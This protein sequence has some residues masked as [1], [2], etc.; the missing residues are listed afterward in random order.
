MAVKGVAAPYAPVS[1]FHRHLRG[2]LTQ[3]ADYVTLVSS[4][5]VSA[6]R[7][8]RCMLSHIDRESTAKNRRADRSRHIT[9]LHLRLSQLYTE[10]QKNWGR[11]KKV[12]QK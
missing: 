6:K 8:S 3:F 10:E 2:I 5:A 4:T 12:R 11:G 1:N 9:T 7:R